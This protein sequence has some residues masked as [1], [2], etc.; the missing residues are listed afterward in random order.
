MQEEGP[1]DV[2]VHGRQ[3]EGVPSATGSRKGAE[4]HSAFDTR[5]RQNIVDASISSQEPG[6]DPDEEPVR[7]VESISSDGW[8]TA[9]TKP[10]EPTRATPLC[11]E[12]VSEPIV[13]SDVS[14]I[15]DEQTKPGSCTEEVGAQAAEA[16]LLSEFSPGGTLAG[17]ETEYDAGIGVQD[18][19]D[20]THA[21]LDTSGLG[22]D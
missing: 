4:G 15:L 6:R 16:L 5:P 22:L 1:R 10:P 7:C 3:Q 12:V 9:Q 2:P 19:L 8:W 21:M 20:V 14:R 13:D 11:R 17:D 18:W